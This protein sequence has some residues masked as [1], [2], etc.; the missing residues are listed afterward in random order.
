MR[1]ALS[2]LIGVLVTLPAHA[3]DARIP[4]LVRQLRN[5]QDARVKAQ[6]V[7]LLG[8]TASIDAVAPLCE[9]LKDAES[10]VRIASANALGVLKQRSATECLKASLTGTVE[11]DETV[12]AALQKAIDALEAP[13]PKVLTV[14]TAKPGALYLNVEPIV[15][16]VGIEEQASLAE[17][18][19]RE[20]L[21]GLGAFFSPAGEDRNKAVALIKSKKLK[22]F[23]LRL[24]LLPG[25]T[26]NGLKVEMLIMSYPD[27]AL[28][29]SWNVKAS[30]G[31]AEALL[32]AMVP[33]VVEDVASDLDWKNEGVP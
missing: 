17:A 11:A 13:P 29:G 27:Q 25:S 12:R 22:A 6:T 24:Q 4:F 7:L 15:D 5:S 16:K 30:G 28:Q 1:P 8:Q 23:Q 9:A 20:S 26:K 21:V 19:L 14:A 2:I 31:N 18:L 32:R 10:V 3:Q 33:R